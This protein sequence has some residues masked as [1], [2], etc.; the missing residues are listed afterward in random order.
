WFH[1]EFAEYFAARFPDQTMTLVI[2]DPDRTFEYFINWKKPEK[3]AMLALHHG[4]KRHHAKPGGTLE[5]VY[6]KLRYT[7]RVIDDSIQ[8]EQAISDDQLRPGDFPW[9]G[10]GWH[11]DYIGGVSGLSK[12]E[13]WEMF[14]LCVD[15]LM[16]LLSAAGRAARA[17]REEQPNDSK[18]KYL[19][20]TISKKEFRSALKAVVAGHGYSSVATRMQATLDEMT[21]LVDVFIDEITLEVPESGDLTPE[22]A[23]GDEDLESDSSHE[24]GGM[25]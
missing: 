21:T 14:C 19:Y 20:V 15:K 12:E 1:G 9:E 16:E 3:Y 22:P 7:L 25:E 2:L 24:E 5:N 10:A 17:K 18:G 11:F 6:G 13:D 8:S 4:P 23:P